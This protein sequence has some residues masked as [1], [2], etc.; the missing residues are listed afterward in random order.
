[1]KRR[2]ALRCTSEERRDGAH[3]SDEPANQERRQ[4]IA[5]KELLDPE[6][7]SLGDV[8]ARTVIEQEPAS[9]PATEQVADRVTAERAERGRER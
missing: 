2:R 3:Q 9:Q 7:T 4:A 5:S 6:Q 8:Y 1:M